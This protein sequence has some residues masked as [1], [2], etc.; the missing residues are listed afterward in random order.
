M[1]DITISILTITI[2]VMLFCGSVI[3]KRR[4]ETND[5]SRTYLGL[6]QL[7]GA[8]MLAT[9]LILSFFGKTIFNTKQLLTPSIITGGTWS[10]SLFMLYPIMVMRAGRLK[11]TSI[12]TLFVPAILMT[13]PHLFG[14]EFIELYSWADFTRNLTQPDVIIR[15][16]GILIAIVISTLL[17]ILPYNWRHSSADFKW[18]IRVTLMSQGITVLYFLALFTTQDI[19]IDLHLLWTSFTTIYFARFELTVRILPSAKS[20]TMENNEVPIADIINRT[21]DLWTNIDYIMDHNQIWRNPDTTVETLSRD[22]GT[23][24]IYVADS[25]RE[26]TGLTFNDYMNRKRATFMADQLRQD[27]N[28]DQKSLFYDAGFRSRQTAYRNFV[29]FIGCSPSDFVS[30]L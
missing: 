11:A 16:L 14:M 27:P 22:I 26:H 4:K 3:F 29:K 7:V 30:S 28:Q 21:Q 24:R 15:L 13:L 19:Y 18:I 12:I 20:E 1:S 5:H 8:G 10:I 25:I 23:N 17:I 9:S 2:V 6:F